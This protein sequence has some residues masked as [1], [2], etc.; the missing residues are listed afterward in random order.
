MQQGTLN[1]VLRC[2]S[3]DFRAAEHEPEVLRFY[4]LAA[5]AQA[6][7][8]CFARAYSRAMNAGFHTHV[9]V[10]CRRQVS[11]FDFRHCEFLKSGMQCLFPNGYAATASGVWA[12]NAAQFPEE[13]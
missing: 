6:M 11:G 12:R 3:T 13:P 4:M 8:H 2:G 10:V 5:K 9:Q 7:L 1:Q